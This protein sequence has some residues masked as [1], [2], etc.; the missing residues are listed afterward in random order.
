MIEIRHSTKMVKNKTLC[1]NFRNFNKRPL[2]TVWMQ[3]TGVWKYG[4]LY[5]SIFS[6][7]PVVFWVFPEAR[8]PFQL[9]NESF[10]NSVDAAKRHFR[11]WLSVHSVLCSSCG[12]LRE[13]C[14]LF[15]AHTAF[16]T[17]C[18]TVLVHGTECYTAAYLA[19]A[20]SRRLPTY[21]RNDFLHQHQS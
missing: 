18:C 17:S 20:L 4:S 1:K 13:A 9:Q 15:H 14:A 11:T 12:I 8:A 7:L 21:R 3:H 5:L 6:V 16:N 10:K 2:K 19:P